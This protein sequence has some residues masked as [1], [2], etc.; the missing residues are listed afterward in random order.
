MNGRSIDGEI[1][2]C[3]N[4]RL[5]FAV[6]V[7]FGVILF[8]AL[9]RAVTTDNIEAAVIV[10][11]FIGIPFGYYM[12]RTFQ[13]RPVLVLD[14][15]AL[16][17]G[18]SRQVIPWDTVFEVHLRQRQ[19]IFGVYHHLVLIVQPVQPGADPQDKR[20]LAELTTSK[21]AVQTVRQPID[22][23]SMSWSDIMALVRQRLGKEIPTRHEAGL[24][25]KTR[26]SS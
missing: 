23:L 1:R 13:R 9:S 22:Q 7:F 8:G 12:R 16:T 2:V 25:G 5:A 20:S 18:R 14:A 24:F 19:S 15:W 21:V 6:A 4:R 11:I 10:V 26:T 17:I 3:V